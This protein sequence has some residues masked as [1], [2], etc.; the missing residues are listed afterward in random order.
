MHG[1]SAREGSAMQAI[2]LAG[3]KGTR[4][5]PFTA[6]VPKPLLPHGD[7][8]IVEVVIRQLA[9][10]GIRRI[11]IAL[12]HMAHL[13][14]ATIGDGSRFGV[15]IEYFIED[16]PMGTAG[17]LRLVRDLGDHFLVINGDPLTT[18]DSVLGEQGSYPYEATG[19]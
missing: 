3:G 1:V 17:P 10:I 9:A 8:P 15:A 13:F 6:T 19:S 4:L 11:A 16:E 12:G 5:R 2:L 14:S 7:L 18:L